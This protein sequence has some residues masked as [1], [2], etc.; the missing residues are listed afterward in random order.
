MISYVNNA[1]DVSPYG[2]GCEAGSAGR[3][4][5]AGRERRM[6]GKNVK[7]LKKACGFM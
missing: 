3:M 7:Q 6:G 2:S 5:R 1:L 4:W